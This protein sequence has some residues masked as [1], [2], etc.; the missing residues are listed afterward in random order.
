MVANPKT[1]PPE[2]LQSWVQSISYYALAD[3][4]VQQLVSKCPHRDALMLRWL[5]APGE[6]VAQAG[7]DL[8]ASK[9]TDKSVR[10]EFFKPYLQRIEREIQAER[11]RV[12][13]AMDGALIAIGMRS[14]NL[15][16]QAV[17]ATRRIGPVI[18]DHGETGCKTPSAEQYIAKAEGYRRR[19]SSAKS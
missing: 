19:K 10:D 18:V 17:A 4:F 8:V 13:H 6:Y 7:W 15:R 11:N 14:E 12:R 3:V 5:E 2:T 9:T 1:V 16:V